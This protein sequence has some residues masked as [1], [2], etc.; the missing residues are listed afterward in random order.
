MTSKFDFVSKFDV[1]ESKIGTESVRKEYFLI[2][3]ITSKFDFLS[4]YKIFEILIDTKI[5][6]LNEII[7][8]EKYLFSHNRPHVDIAH[9][10]VLSNFKK[11][12]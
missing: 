5:S 11:A 1:S 8:F 4:I 3:R 9:K 12:S 7:I 6:Y 10:I 2:H